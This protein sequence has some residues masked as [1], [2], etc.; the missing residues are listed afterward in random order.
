MAWLRSG[1]LEARTRSE[2]FRP[3]PPT[4]VQSP[5]ASSHHDTQSQAEKR[6]KEIVS[7]LGGGEVRVQR[8]GGGFRDSDTV[9]KGK[10]PNPPKDQRH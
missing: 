4:A 3:E 2:T 5:R 9:P 1:G 10:D 8:R 6:A 7:N